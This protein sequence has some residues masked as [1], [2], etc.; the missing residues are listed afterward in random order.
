MRRD[1]AGLLETNRTRLTKMALA[2]EKDGAPC[3]PH[4][5][6]NPTEF[7]TLGAIEYVVHNIAAKDMR[8]EMIRRVIS[9]AAANDLRDWKRPD[10]KKVEDDLWDWNDTPY[11][12]VGGCYRRFSFCRIVVRRRRSGAIF[13][14]PDCFDARR[15]AFRLQC[16]DTP[17]HAEFG[18]CPQLHNRLH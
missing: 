2:R 9:V 4:C 7:S 11:R 3:K 8:E 1:C 5:Y 17:S 14:A 16:A 12:K 13:H 6:A 15:V 10:R 18:N